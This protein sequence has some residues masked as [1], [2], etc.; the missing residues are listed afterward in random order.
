V[1]RKLA[2]VLGLHYDTRSA[3]AG[4]ADTVVREYRVARPQQTEAV[5]TR[6]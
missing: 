4:A 6:F 2:Q 1:L 3:L 5:I